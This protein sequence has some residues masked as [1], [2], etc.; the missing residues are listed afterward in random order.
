M[1]TFA[2]TCPH[3]PTEIFSWIYIER[4]GERE[5]HILERTSQELIKKS[6]TQVNAQSCTYTAILQILIAKTY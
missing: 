1:F 3:A 2:N 5:A 4:E 6:N